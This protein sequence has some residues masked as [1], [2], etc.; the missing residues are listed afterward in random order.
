MTFSAV[1]VVFPGKRNPIGFLNSI[2]EVLLGI[3][4]VRYENEA[5]DQ[6]N[7]NL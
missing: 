4:H 2:P 3:T 5:I 6:A 1:K 7:Y